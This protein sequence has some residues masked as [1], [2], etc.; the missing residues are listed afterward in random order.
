MSSRHPAP[1]KSSASAQSQVAGRCADRTAHNGHVCGRYAALRDATEIAE[2][3]G[4]EQLPT[5]DAESSR[6]PRVPNYNVTPTSEVFIVMS[7]DGVRAV[8]C[9]HWGLIPSWSSDASRSSRMINARSETV[10]TK[11]AFRAAFKR[12]RCLVPADGYYEWQARDGRSK[13]PYFIHRGDEAMVAF[14]GLYED[15]DGPRGRV[16]SCTVLTQDS[17]GPLASIHDRMPVLVSAQDW[18]SWLDPQFDEPSSLLTSLVS[19]GEAAL[20]R[21]YPVSTAVNKPGNNGA[22]LLDPLASDDT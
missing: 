2:F 13:Q 20:L 17:H 6:S 14:A 16:R 4:A 22:Q 11:P 8:D 5:T 19:D 15:W 10:A 12:R 21:A 1:D 3:F 7:E 18:A 9:A